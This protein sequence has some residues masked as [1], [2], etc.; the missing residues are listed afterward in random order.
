MFNEH[1]NSQS[2]HL[3]LIDKPV[4]GRYNQVNASHTG[5]TALHRKSIDG[6]TPIG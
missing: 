2:Y 6:R 5:I 1:D 4:E 3:L